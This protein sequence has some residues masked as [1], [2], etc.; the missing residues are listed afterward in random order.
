M[1]FLKKFLSTGV[2]YL[3]LN[4]LLF[5]YEVTGLLKLM[6]KPSNPLIVKMILLENL[7]LFMFHR[8]L[9][10]RNHFLNFL[11]NLLLKLFHIVLFLLVLINNFKLV[12]IN[13]FEVL[14]SVFVYFVLVLD[15]LLFFLSVLKFYFFF[16]Y[17]SDEVV[18]LGLEFGND[19]SFFYVF[20][21]HCAQLNF[22]LA[23]F[24]SF[25]DEGTY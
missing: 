16:S 9:L 2:F 6:L 13:L 22:Q 11:L 7:L 3:G 20:T 1:C 12:F 10:L 24:A 8:L 15:D 14:Y 5:F 23:I 18:F 4:L 21:L 19:F 17:L 25:N